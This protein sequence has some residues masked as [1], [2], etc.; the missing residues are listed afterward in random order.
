VY[1]D[2]RYAEE[3]IDI[4]ESHGVE[5]QL[6]GRVEPHTGKKVTILGPYGYFEY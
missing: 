4:A 1:L 3:I 5:A 2:E 6:I